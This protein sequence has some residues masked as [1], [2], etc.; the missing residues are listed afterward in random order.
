M[1]AGYRE[2]KGVAS[3]HDLTVAYRGSDLGVTADGPT[4]KG[5]RGSAHS[6]SG[7]APCAL[8]SPPPPIA[9][10]NENQMA[11]RPSLAQEDILV[12]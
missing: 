12:V 3:K 11:S 7:S 1:K 5:M 4:Q 6:R 9:G 8:T 2:R 10:L